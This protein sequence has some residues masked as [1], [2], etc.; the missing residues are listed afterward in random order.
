MHNVALVLV[1]GWAGSVV[2]CGLMIVCAPTRRPSMVEKAEAI[3]RACAMRER[4]AR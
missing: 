4:V 1:Y 3:V 2:I